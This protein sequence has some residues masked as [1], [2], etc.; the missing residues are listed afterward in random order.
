MK[1]KLLI[2]LIKKDFNEPLVYRTK[3]N[4]GK[5]YKTQ[6]DTSLF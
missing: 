4:D 1:M 5:K 6:E 3:I 2:F